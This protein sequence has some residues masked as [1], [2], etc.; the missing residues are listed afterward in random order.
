MKETTNQK[1]ETNEL[2]Q[3]MNETEMLTDFQA[4]LKEFYVGDVS[5]DGEKLILS[6][7]NGQRFQI[8]VQEI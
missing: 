2:A 8:A 1:N 4:L 7:T 3:R 6:L 5:K